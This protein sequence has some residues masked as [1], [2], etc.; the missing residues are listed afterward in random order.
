MRR[1][2][3]AIVTLMLAATV[4]APAVTADQAKAK[5]APA[6]PAVTSA[7]PV[8]INTASS[9]QIEVLPGIGAR[10]AER[11]VEYRQKNGGFKKIE[12]L[13]NVKGIG[14][15]SFLKLKPLITVSADKTDRATGK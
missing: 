7:S 5:P 15:K 8:N 1:L 2:S 13:M 11:I 14:E 9:S 3:C 6:K 12:E 4:G 10:T